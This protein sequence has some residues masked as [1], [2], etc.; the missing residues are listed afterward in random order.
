M[1]MVPECCYISACSSNSKSGVHT[2]VLQTTGRLTCVCV[3]GG[4]CG[5]GGRGGGAL[6]RKVGRDSMNM[7][8]VH[9]PK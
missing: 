3:G 5:G 4:V 1:T 9:A 8:N 6:S 7:L 2:A